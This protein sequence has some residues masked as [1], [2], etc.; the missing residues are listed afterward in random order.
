MDKFSNIDKIEAKNKEN[1][2]E[3]KYKGEYLNVIDYKDYEFVSEPSMVVMLP[4]LR[5]EGQILLRH[6]YI[7]TYQY[8]FRNSNEYKG[9]TN[10]LT[11]I[12]GQMEKNETVENTIRRELYE[13][14]G[15]I[16]SNSYE[17]DNGKSLFVSK[18]NVALYHACILE[19]RYNDYKLTKPPT[20]GSI[21]E[22]KSNTIKISVGDID[23]IRT[24][25]LIT[26]YLITK[27]KLDY[28]IK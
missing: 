6:E 23:E 17:I 3:F 21:N 1:V 11:V 5:D 18:S 28:K 7:P 22:K 14:T 8:Y 27:F 12:S 2:K 13:E 4:Y 26:E 9:I 19:I 25:D 16:L 15:I 20:D 24:H 10:F